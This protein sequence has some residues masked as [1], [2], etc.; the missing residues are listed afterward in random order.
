[1]IVSELLILQPGRS[2]PSC[3]KSVSVSSMSD[4]SSSLREPHASILDVYQ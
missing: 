3:G 2:H 4:N 1:M